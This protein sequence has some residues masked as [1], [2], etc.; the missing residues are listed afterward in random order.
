MKKHSKYINQAGKKSK[1]GT[2]KSWDLSKEVEKTRQELHRTYERRGLGARCVDQQDLAGRFV[3]ICK[4]SACFGRNI[5][6]FT[7]EIA[8]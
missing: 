8:L 4:E 5:A 6:A 1:V 2:C 3:F 7:S